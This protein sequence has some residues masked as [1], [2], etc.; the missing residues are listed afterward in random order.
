MK[1]ITTTLL[2]LILCTPGWAVDMAK[3]QGIHEG[4]ELRARRQHL[5]SPADWFEIG[6]TVGFITGFSE[7]TPLVHPLPAQVEEN[8]DAVCKYIDLHPEIWSLWRQ[9]GMKL[10][11]TMLYGTSDA[12]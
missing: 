9:E 3:L 1:A 4:C 5:H 12:R 6:R 7:A 10:V 8:L 11:L 2:G